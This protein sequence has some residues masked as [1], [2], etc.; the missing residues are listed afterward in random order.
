MKN[1]YKGLVLRTRAST[2]STSFNAYNE[3]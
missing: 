2:L 3:F 1:K